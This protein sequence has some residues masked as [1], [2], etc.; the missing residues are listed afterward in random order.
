MKNVGYDLAGKRFLLFIIH[1]KN[2]SL[3]QALKGMSHDTSSV[4]NL[5]YYIIMSKDL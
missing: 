1:L 4:Y 3:T 5:H 2:I